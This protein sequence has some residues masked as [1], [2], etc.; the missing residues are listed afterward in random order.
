MS[1]STA[2]GALPN[3]KKIIVPLDGSEFSFAAARYAVYLAKR[4][5]A[6]IVFM[7]SIVNPPYADYSSVGLMLPRYLEEARLK[8][9]GWFAEVR[10]IAMRED[11]K[12]STEIILD[13]VSVPSSIVE[14]AEKELADLIVIGTRGQSGIKRF[15]LGSVASGVVSHAHCSVLVVRK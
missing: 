2:A 12:M 14:F 6:E 3:I 8:A 1:Q 10:Q 5:G 7:H 13:V 9:E 15:L 4:S 11:V